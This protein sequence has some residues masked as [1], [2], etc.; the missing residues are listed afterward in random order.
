MRIKLTRQEFNSLAE[1][2]KALVGQMGSDDL[3]E[4]LLLTMMQRLMLELEQKRLLVKKAYKL[5]WTPERALAFAIVV[6]DCSL[7]AHTYEGALVMKIYN[8]I[9]Q[10]VAQ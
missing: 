9:Q 10:E 2:I 5:N 3:Y 6:G 4:K 8:Q 7:K 1:I